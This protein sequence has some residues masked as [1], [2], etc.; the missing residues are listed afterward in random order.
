M[1]DKALLSFR[2]SGTTPNTHLTSASRELTLTGCYNF[3]IISDRPVDS[4]SSAPQFLCDEAEDGIR[5]I[6]RLLPV[7]V[8]PHPDTSEVVFHTYSNTVLF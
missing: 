4:R 1:N 7:I 6:P 2:E 8:S 5:P 3:T